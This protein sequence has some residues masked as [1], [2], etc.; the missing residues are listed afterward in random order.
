MARTLCLLFGVFFGSGL[1]NP[2]LADALSAAERQLLE[3]YLAWAAPQAL[4]GQGAAPQSLRPAGCATPALHRLHH[5]R[6]DLGPAAKSLLQGLGRPQRSFS[7]LSDSGRFRLHYD[8]DGAHAVTPAY[9]EK[10]AALID[11]AWTL[12]IDGLGYR[13][14]PADNGRDG[15]EWDIYFTQLGAGAFPSYGGVYPEN[16]TAAPNATSYMVVDNDFAD[17]GFRQTRGL[18]GLRVT[19]AHEFFHMVQFGYYDGP[20]DRWWQEAT[21]TWI[22]EVAFPQV[23]DYYQYLAQ[24][25]SLAHP[26]TTLESPLLLYG[27]ALFAF[28]L[29][30][31]HG[32]RT[33]RATWEEITRRGRARLADFDAVVPGGLAAAAQDYALWNYFTG[34]RSI[35]GRFYPEAAAYPAAAAAALEASAKAVAVREGRADALASAYI[36]LRPGGRPGGVRLAVD[37]PQGRWLKKLLLVRGDS[38]E[39]RRA[40][41]DLI[42]VA[43]WDAYDEIVLVLT[44][45]EEDRLGYPY[46]VQVEY[47]PL[48]GR[49]TGP[50]SFSFGPAYPQPFR[51]GNGTPLRLPFAL[52]R[53]SPAT[54]LGI[55]SAD[56]R[57]VRAFDLGPLPGNSRQQVSWDGRNAAGRRVAP[58]VYYGV[59]EAS[60]SRRALP[61]ALLPPAGR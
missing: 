14:P 50:L 36:P 45:A 59:L 17:P 2:L 26:G 58:G 33:V 52:T 56:G 53:D 19:L 8:L 49:D 7:R 51:A 44:V 39:T 16:P 5:A 21:A 35:A 15:P 54:R 46:R 47:D 25:S 10:A 20:D 61:L 40:G 28:F 11:S 30:Q 23:N 24:A 42:E 18:D 60:G 12:E 43:D 37:T 34:G 32:P 31:R 3:P 27:N 13:P 38:L 4:S 48:L 57:L 9:L 55:Y 41:A 1:P 6:E 22:E 29:E